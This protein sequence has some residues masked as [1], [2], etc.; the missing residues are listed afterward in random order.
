MSTLGRAGLTL[1]G[2]G[3]LM[4]LAGIATDRPVV[5]GVGLAMLCAGFT[6]GILGR[7]R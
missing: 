1:S 2:A 6:A 5:L 3:A 7:A 4:E